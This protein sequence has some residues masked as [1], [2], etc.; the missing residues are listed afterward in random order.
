MAYKRYFES[1]DVS[2]SDSFVKELLG[3]QNQVKIFHW[4]TSSYATHK[5]LGDYYDSLSDLIDTFVEQYQGQFG[6]VPIKSNLGQSDNIGLSDLSGE[7][8]I[9]LF[10]KNVW[11][12]LTTLRQNTENEPNTTNLQN[13][14]DEMIGE[15]AKL[16][17]LLT[18]E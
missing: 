10:V 9:V 11:Q 13:L 3:I 4:Q 2:P 18:L 8:Q 17:Y 7:E 6:R 5:A 12:W 14:I 16:K 15:T 1:I